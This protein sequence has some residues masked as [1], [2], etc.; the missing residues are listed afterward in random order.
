ME[1]ILAVLLG[2]GILLILASYPVGSL[3]VFAFGI[4]A[5]CSSLL[6][7]HL[8]EA[9]IAEWYIW[10]I[11]VGAVAGIVYIILLPDNRHNPES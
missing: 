2:S 6:G 11:A 4:L 1:S 10:I 3:L 7:A 8:F 9:K 5:V